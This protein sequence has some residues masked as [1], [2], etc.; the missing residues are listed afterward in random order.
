MTRRSLPAISSRRRLKQIE[1]ILT[2]AN[3]EK[4]ITPDVL[5]LP[6][7]VEEGTNPEAALVTTKH[8]SS[9][10]EAKKAALLAKK[11]V[12]VIKTELHGLLMEQQT[13]PGRFPV[14]KY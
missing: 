6:L 14:L 1:T 12:E 11:R 3:A 2:E 13:A 10:I 8:R 9:I 4:N 7:S 5:Q